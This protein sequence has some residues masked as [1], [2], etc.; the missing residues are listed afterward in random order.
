LPAEKPAV[1]SPPNPLC[2]TKGREER[3]L[4]PFSRLS[5]LSEEQVKKIRRRVRA[6]ELIID[7]AVEYDVDRKTIRR[8]LDAADQADRERAQQR[9]ARRAEQKRMQRLL[10]S[11]YRNPARA[12]EHQPRTRAQR[13]ES[14]DP[15]PSS[16]RSPQTS[17]ASFGHA[18]IFPKTRNGLL[19]R[20]AY[21]E[22]RKLNNLPNSLLD[23]HDVLHG[24]ET[25]DERRARKARAAARSR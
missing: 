11:A 5:P 17:T 6:G 24:R 2:P 25:P 10:G 1:E 23:Y 7:L 19:E 9:A 14:A 13:E 8:R 15:R 22:A 20:L 3:Q 18:P 12:P 16:Q 21:Y 4:K